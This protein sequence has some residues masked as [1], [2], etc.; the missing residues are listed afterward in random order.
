MNILLCGADGFIGSALAA[1]LTQAGHTVHRAVRTPCLPGDIAV[2]FRRDLDP[3]RWRERLRGC[4]A[5]INAVGIL[6]ENAAGDFERI[7]HLAP[8]ALFTACA[9]AGVARVIQISALGAQTG[10]TPYLASKAAADRALRQ[11][12]VAGVVVRPGLVFGVDGASSRLFL[13]LAGLPLIGLPGGGTQRLRPIHVDDL[14]ALVCAAIEMPQ[15]PRVID[16]VGGEELTYAQLLACYRLALGYPP[17]IGFP[18]PAWLMDATAKL[19]AHLPGSLLTPDT[20]QMLRAGNTADVADTARL[21]GRMPRAPDRFLS[22]DEAQRLRARRQARWQDG[23]MRT[24]LALVWIGSGAVSLALPQTGLDLLGA[25]GLS[26][27]TAALVL[28]GAAALD[29][30]LGAATVIRPSRRQWLAQMGVVALYSL[31]IAWRLP[32]F[33]VHPF[34]PVLKNLPILAMLALLWAQARRA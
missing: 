24:A 9:E 12:P 27:G 20:W 26:G 17:A 6:R 15:P 34:G 4:D 16:A 10:G 1:A 18:L 7:H 22:T 13:T 3:A 14:C 28:W 29:I 25:F 30:A 23:V 33:L 8:A 11:S 32:A 2:D 21:L 19:A 31:L 5:A